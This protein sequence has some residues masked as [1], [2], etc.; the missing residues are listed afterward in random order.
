MEAVGVE[1]TGPKVGSPDQHQATPT[2]DLPGWIGEEGT[3]WV[4]QPTTPGGAGVCNF[5]GGTPLHRVGG[6]DLETTR[7]WPSTIRS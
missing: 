5:A 2:Y 7:F 6:Y 1:P 4:R 3:L